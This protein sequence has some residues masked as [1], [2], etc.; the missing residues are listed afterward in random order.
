[1]QIAELAV[2]SQRVMKAEA[3]IRGRP[4]K[5]AINRGDT[6]HFKS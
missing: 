3:I 1:M 4:Q 6:L 5:V 2:R